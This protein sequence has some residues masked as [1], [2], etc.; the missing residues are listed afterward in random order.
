MYIEDEDNESLDL[1][2]LNTTKI[3]IDN[4]DLSINKQDSLPKIIV[5]KELSLP[6]LLNIT[7]EKQDNF[8]NFL[9]KSIN[10]ATEK[11]YYRRTFPDSK[12]MK[13]SLQKD[14]NYDSSDGYEEGSFLGD[15]WCN[16]TVVFSNS[17]KVGSCKSDT[18]LSS[19]ESLE[20]SYY[21]I[22]ESLSDSCLNRRNSTFN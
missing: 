7:E 3:F 17:Y 16:R 9:S 4:L 20:T 11:D 6:N 21:S 19:E 22:A 10:L 1:D 2:E 5:H 8:T 15:S 12:L 13:S 14:L 18:L